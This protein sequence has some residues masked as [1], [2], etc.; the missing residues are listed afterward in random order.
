MLLHI[1]RFGLH[2]HFSYF[3]T[4][5]IYTHL[6]IEMWFFYLI[7]LLCTTNILDQ[8]HTS[9]F[10]INKIFFLRFVYFMSTIVVFGTHHGY[11]TFIIVSPV[12]ITPLITPLITSWVYFSCRC[13]S[14]GDRESDQQ[15]QRPIKYIYHLTQVS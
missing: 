10:S 5:N 11:N 7:L 4:T 3:I 8:Y 6:L 13:N 2:K 15:F 1:F 12:L 14:L 9:V